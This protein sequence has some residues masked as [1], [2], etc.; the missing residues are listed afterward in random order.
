[1][2]LLQW[3]RSHERLN[4]EHA[5]GMDFA[6]HRESMVLSETQFKPSKKSN[7]RVHHPQSGAEINILLRARARTR[8]HTFG[9]LERFSPRAQIARCSSTEFS[10]GNQTHILRPSA[11]SHVIIHLRCK[12][13]RASTGC[14]AH[15]E[16]RPILQ[17]QNMSIILAVSQNT[18]LPGRLL[19][20]TAKA[21][22]PEALT[23]TN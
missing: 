13:H 17:W 16:P 12:G 8:A 20:K 3:P 5:K 15:K 23:V 22:K 21:P 14:A 7:P 6:L 11:S 2:T 18:W 1:M 9:Y 4:S 10:S 19:P